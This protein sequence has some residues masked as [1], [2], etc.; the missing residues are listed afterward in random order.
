MTHF[1]EHPAVHAF[2]LSLLPIAELRGG[3][4]YA[5]ASGI[6]P[7]AAYGLCVLSNLLVIPLVFIFLETAHKLFYTIPLYR[8][9]FDSYQERVRKRAERNIHR[10]GY[11]G[12]MMFVAIPLPITGAYTG[13]V[14]AW[15]LRLDRKRSI[16]YLVLGVFVAGVIVLTATMTGVGLLQLFTK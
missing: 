8:T 13:T 16:P 12:V 3:I 10:W 4:P 15:L 1:L 14:A 7:L 9:L 11:W 5:V 2:V 6:N